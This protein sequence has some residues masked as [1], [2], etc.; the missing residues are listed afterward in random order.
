MEQSSPARV[1]ADPD[2]MEDEEEEEDPLLTFRHIRTVS[3]I[4]PSGDRVRRK[5][6]LMSTHN[7]NPFEHD[8]R[9]PLL[10]T[11]RSGTITAYSSMPGSAID[12][13]IPPWEPTQ[14]DKFKSWL[15]S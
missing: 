4:L 1:Q 6:S 15:Q 12:T 9:R 7:E 10:D 11:S 14:F 5:V 3:V 8:E 2:E 13:E